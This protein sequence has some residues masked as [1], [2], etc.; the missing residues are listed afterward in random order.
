MSGSRSP[1]VRA[2]RPDHEP[3]ARTTVSA[4]TFRRSSTGCLSKTPPRSKTR[5]RSAAMNRP[6]VR[7][8]S[9]SN[10]TPPTTS[11]ST[12]GSA[13]ATSS[14]LSTVAR[15]PRRFASSAKC[16]SPSCARWVRLSI[17]SPRRPNGTSSSSAIRA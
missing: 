5:F 12:S 2:K 16:A 17:I 11:V 3:A 4:S 9:S 8:A 10:S 1:I 15:S 7:C 6:G 13:R 14:R